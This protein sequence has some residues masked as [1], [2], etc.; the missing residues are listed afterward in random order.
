[1]YPDVLIINIVTVIFSLIVIVSVLLLH[2]KNKIYDYNK[3][4]YE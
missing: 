1:M 2:S 4:K 3:I